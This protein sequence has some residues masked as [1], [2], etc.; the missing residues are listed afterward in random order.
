MAENSMP[1]AHLFQCMNSNSSMD[2]WSHPFKV[3][4]EFTNPLS[5][6]NGATF[7]FEYKLV[8]SPTLSEHAG[9]QVNPC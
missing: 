8:I 1:G 4:D 6:S 2:K 7:K 3:L 9:I 5:N